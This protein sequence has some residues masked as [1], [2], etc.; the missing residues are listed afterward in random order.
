[1]IVFDTD[2]LSFFLRRSPPAGLIRRLA[3]LAPASQATTA[4]NVAELAYGAQRMRDPAPLLE[5]MDRLLW[6]NLQVLAFEERAAHIHGKLRA[7]LESR[8]RAVSEPDLR[9]ASI[10]LRHDAR[11]A[12]GNLRHFLSIPGLDAEDWLS[13]HR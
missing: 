12:T 3:S 2:V 13:E 6:P 10:C 11:L 8:G 7:S 4:I 9:I 5:S 1:M